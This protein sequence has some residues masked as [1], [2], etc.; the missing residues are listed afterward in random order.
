MSDIS[1]IAAIAMGAKIIEKHFT[2]DKKLYGP[3]HRM[4]ANPKEL[5]NYFFNIREA[6][7]SMG[8]KNKIVLN[9]EKQNKK[10]LKKSIVSITDVKK[11][12][13]ITLKNISFKRPG[14]GLRPIEINK[15]LN[16]K[17][18]KN[19]KKNTLIKINMFNG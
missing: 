7:K 11:N 12:D 15:I 8:I 10:K 3:D 6:E 4:S 16:K 1:G 2:I 18:N 9:S 17:I 19:I 5:F 13:K 14:T